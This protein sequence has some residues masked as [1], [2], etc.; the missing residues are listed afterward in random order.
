SAQPDTP[1]TVDE[2]GV[3]RVSDGAIDASPTSPTFTRTTRFTSLGLGLASASANGFYIPTVIGFDQLVA[4]YGS[5]GEIVSE[6]VFIGNAAGLGG[7]LCTGD[8]YVD[9]GST[10]TRLDSLGARVEALNVPGG[11]GGGVVADCAAQ[12]VFVTD[13]ANGVVNVFTPAA[14]SSPTITPDSESVSKVTADSANVTVQVNPRSDPGEPAT[15]Y[16]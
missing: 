16:H 11:S 15:A 13:T 1:V 14:P 12:S 7:E 8:L 3:F 10:V 9:S 4:E 5:A 6:D 2:K